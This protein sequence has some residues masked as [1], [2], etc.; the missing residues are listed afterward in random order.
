MGRF[1]PREKQF[2]ALQKPKAILEEHDLAGIQRRR[3]ELLD[4]F[5]IRKTRFQSEIQQQNDIVTEAEKTVKEYEEKVGVT[6]HD[7]R[8]A[9]SLFS[10]WGPAEST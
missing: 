3:A 8:I 2:E 10:R 6:R 1:Q 4:K 9:M 7:I 5:N